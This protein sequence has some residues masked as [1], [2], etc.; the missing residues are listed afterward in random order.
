MNDEGLMRQRLRSLG[1]NT[2]EDEEWG[3][4][5]EGTQVALHHNEGLEVDGKWKK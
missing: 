3:I 4:E 5:H 1:R 2:D